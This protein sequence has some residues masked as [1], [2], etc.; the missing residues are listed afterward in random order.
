MK[1]S[2][3][4]ALLVILTLA[5]GVHSVLAGSATISGTLTPG[6]ATML[7]ATITDPNCAGGYGGT[8]VLYQ[9]Y[10]FSVDVSGIYTITEPGGNSAIYV[11]EG[12]FNPAAAADNCIAASNINPI[13]LNVA[14]NAG[15]QYFLVI[16]DDT[17]AQAGLSYTLTI[18]GPGNI[19]FGG[20]CT[21]PLPAGSAIYSVPAG[22]PAFYAA[23]LSTQTN[24]NLPAGTWYISE[25]TGD[26]AKVWIACA[27]NPI[28]IPANAVAR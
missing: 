2:I 24:F 3:V 14:L 21:N 15:T 25:F 16:I 19:S 27:A 26:F 28:Y 20:A 17:F 6:G 23:D 1:K 18:N 10:P 7:V 4:T 12:S 8:N 13:S 11:Y 22:A 9:S 5:A